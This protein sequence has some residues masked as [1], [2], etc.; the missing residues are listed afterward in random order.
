MQGVIQRWMLGGGVSVQSDSVRVASKFGERTQVRSRGGRGALC[1]LRKSAHRLSQRE[2]SGVRFR[3]EEVD[4]RFAS[5]S[6][7]FNLCVGG[8]G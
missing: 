8:S 7:T 2:H 4:L 3:E 1:S 6:L 5:R